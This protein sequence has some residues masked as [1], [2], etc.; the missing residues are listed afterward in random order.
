MQESAVLSQRVAMRRRFLSLL[1]DRPIWLRQRYFNLVVWC[2]VAADGVGG[3]HCLDLG[4]DQF[5]AN[6]VGIITLIG[7]QVGD[8]AH[9]RAETLGIVRL[10]RVSARCQHGVERASLCVASGVEPGGKPAA[11]ASQRLGLPSSFFIPTAQ[12]CARTAVL[13][14]MSALASRSTA[15]ASVSSI[16]SNTPVMVQRRQRRNTLFHL[17]YPSGRRR[18]C[19][20]VRAIHIM[21]S[22]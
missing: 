15:C 1:N 14:I 4:I 8:H 19:A 13:S 16:A 3:D 6:R 2:G 7:D 22:E 17:P 12:W 10:H 9:Q 11:R 18:H 20:P 21:P 5:L